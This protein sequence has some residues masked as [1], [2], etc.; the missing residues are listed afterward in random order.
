M[1]SYNMA[2]TTSVARQATRAIVPWLRALPQTIAVRSVEDDP[3][4]WALDVDLLWT[5]T[6]GTYRVEI[7][8]DRHDGSGNFFF[9]TWSNREL[10]TPGCFLYSAADLLFYYFVHSHRLYI[11]P[12]RATRAWFMARRAEFRE[13]AATT[14]VGDGGYTTLGR[15]VPIARVLREVRGVRRFQIADSPAAAGSR[16]RIGTGGV[17]RR[18]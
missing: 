8:A 14:R 11:L 18:R 17:R 7:K 12:L 2:A 3:A 9:E 10:G 16:L 15:L 5:T 13:R 6:R 4:Y 1:P